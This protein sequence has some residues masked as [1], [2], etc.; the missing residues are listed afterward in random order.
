MQPS[1]MPP[2]QASLTGS[3]TGQTNQSY[4]LTT[5]GT[6]DW[7][8]WGLNTLKTPQDLNHKADVQQQISNFT[9]VG[10]STV[11]RTSYS[12]NSY[13]GYIKW[14]DGRPEATAPQQVSGVYVT[15]IDNGFSITI[16]ASTTPKTLKLYIGANLAHGELTASLDGQR[17]YD[18]T[19]DMTHDPNSSQ[20]AGIYTLV[21]NG[22][23]PNQAL[24]VTYTAIATNG[25]NGYVLLEAATLQ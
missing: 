22:S 7:A 1:P 25:S 18:A 4:D 9:V 15:G 12:S 10:H 21:F 14:S 11:Q 3:Y 5:E 8:V 23:A 13:L 2:V 17:Y 20:G 16:P 6:L 19:L 24:T